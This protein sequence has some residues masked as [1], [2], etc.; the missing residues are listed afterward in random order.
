MIEI[1]NLRKVFRQNVGNPGFWRRLL[2]RP[3]TTELVAIDDLSLQIKEGEFFSLLGP[4]GAGKTSTVKILCT[5]L[6]PDGGSCKVAGLDVL[7]HAKD[8]RRQI[9]VS[10]RGERSVY[11]RLSGRQNL[12]YFASLY[13][14]RG[15][16][17]KSRIDEIAEVVG[18]RNRID[19]YVERYSMGMKQRLA[20]GVSIVHR[21]KVLLLDEPTI[22]L[23][24]HGARALRSL[25]RD[26]LC[27]A[28]GVAVLY[29]THNM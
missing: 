25:I 8:V 28:E 26:D 10:I 1:H 5:L 2:T 12:E 27:T 19:N 9:G 4:N 17:A 24:P 22:G 16:A 14:I 3:T 6:L 20:I 23:D 15:S 13:G 21:P 7:S 11:W 29:T 18:L